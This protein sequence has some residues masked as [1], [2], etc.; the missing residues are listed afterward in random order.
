MSGPPPHPQGLIIRFWFCLWKSKHKCT[1]GTERTLSNLW[2]CVKK[3]DTTR[4]ES[5]QVLTN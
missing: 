1:L 5:S 3:L 4:D 2:D